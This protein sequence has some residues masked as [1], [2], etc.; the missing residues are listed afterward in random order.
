MKPGFCDSYLLICE[1]ARANGVER[2]ENLPGCWEYRLDDCW[3]F[4]IN[5]H[6]HTVKHAGINVPAGLC[7]ILYRGFLAGWITPSEIHLDARGH[8]AAM[9]LSSAIARELEMMRRPA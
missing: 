8:G 2:Y 4:A 6:G 7:A 9:E 1:L 5:G 3:T